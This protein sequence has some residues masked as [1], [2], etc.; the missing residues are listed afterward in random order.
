MQTDYFLLCVVE[1]SFS[2]CAVMEWCSLH[3]QWCF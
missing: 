2:C 1:T 3:Q